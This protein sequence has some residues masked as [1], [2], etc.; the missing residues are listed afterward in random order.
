MIT[1]LRIAA[2]LLLLAM[3]AAA[4][5]NGSNEKALADKAYQQQPAAVAKEEKQEDQK[6]PVVQSATPPAPGTW[7]KK[8]IKN[9]NLNL[10]VRNYQT[11]N[12]AIH[13]IAKQFG[14]YIARE[15]QTQSGNRIENRVVLKIP[16]EKFEDAMSALSPSGE[17]IIDRNIN[18]EDVTG[19]MVDVQAR[20]EAKKQARLKYLDL[21]KQ[22]KNMEEVLQVQQELNQIQ[23]ETETAAGRMK[24][25]NYAAAYSTI[26]LTFFQVLNTTPG[27]SEAPSFWQRTVTA[28]RNGSSWL[29]DLFLFLIAAWPAWCIAIAGWWIYRK[30]KMQVVKN[31]Q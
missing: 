19:E 28:F 14:G 1:S 2:A 7:D 24:Y 5:K 16:V 27:D 20:I 12:T 17:K 29:S 13:S 30:W 23:E 25:L 15:E 26:H 9:G 21:L 11:F 3:Q 18:A 10:E 31:R 4:C 8:I 22:A 6:Q